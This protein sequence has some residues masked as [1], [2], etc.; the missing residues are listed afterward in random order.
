MTE[1]EHVDL[2][3]PASFDVL[4]RLTVELERSDIADP[5]I[6]ARQVADGI[7]DERLREAVTA[8]LV[9]LAGSVEARRRSTARTATGKPADPLSS[10]LPTVIKE[11]AGPSGRRAVTQVGESHWHRTAVDYRTRLLAQRIAVGGEWKL[12]RDCTRDDLLYAAEKRHDQAVKVAAQGD[13]FLKLAD[14]MDRAGV[15]RV[16]DLAARDFPK[17]E[18]ALT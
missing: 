1:P 11:G 4:A 8:A 2:V 13:W 17:P 16:I 18:I 12:L 14:V 15:A 6:V 3:G 5:K 7:P 9:A 10:Y